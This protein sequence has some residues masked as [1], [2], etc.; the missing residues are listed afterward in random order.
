MSTAHQMAVIKRSI[1]EQSPIN[2]QNKQSKKC[3]AVFID[4]L[5]IHCIKFQPQMFRLRA[6]LTY[7]CH[8]L[9]DRILMLTSR[10]QNLLFQERR[11]VQSKR[12]GENENVIINLD[13]GLFTQ[14]SPHSVESKS[15][16]TWAHNQI[17]IIIK[18]TW[19]VVVKCSQL[20][21]S[22]PSLWSDLFFLFVSLLTHMKEPQIFFTITNWARKILCTPQML[23]FGLSVHEHWMCYT[24]ILYL[25]QNFARTFIVISKLT[26]M[27]ERSR[28][29]RG[30][31][32]CSRAI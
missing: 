11:N 21:C 2:E 4:C 19:K 3:Y 6:P 20:I 12:E 22:S 7:V 32:M 18:I 25:F 14:F 1:I 13:F 27:C 5:R 9:L 17:I 10:K 30:F 8:D 31:T 23:F 15:D 28:D 16:E 24:L 29:A 26:A